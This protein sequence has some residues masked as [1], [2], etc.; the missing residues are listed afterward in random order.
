MLGKYLNS[1]LMTLAGAAMLV[2]GGKGVNGPAGATPTP[3]PSPT[4]PPAPP[5][6]SLAAPTAT[7]SS[8]APYPAFGHAPDYS[9]IAGQVMVTRIQGGC[10]YVRYGAGAGDE[11]VA[12]GG[13]GWAGADPAL[14]Q[15][16]ALVVIFGHIAGEG[17]P[18][19]MCPGRAFIV[20]RM[21]DNT[22][23]PGRAAL[24]TPT[25]VPA[26]TGV[27]VGTSIPGGPVEG[28]PLRD[29]PTITPAPTGALTP[30]ANGL[31]TVTEADNGRTAEMHLGDT[32]QL[33][34]K[35]DSGY[36]W[37][38]TLSDPSILN[39]DANTLN[40]N[41]QGRYVALARGQT[42]LSAVGLLPCHK[43]NPPCEAPTRGLTL[44]VIVR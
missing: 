5:T 33:A 22:G 32:L 3:E 19:E 41:G 43:V 25:V 34:L 44:Q 29:L 20:D 12:P 7:A 23:A 4:I 2:A 35:D 8:N 37:T 18:H 17:E 13:A 9:W 16:G 21:Q 31:I 30:D 24:P 1:L 27:I 39:Q 40:L 6:P 36:T 28:P 42:T 10:T 15:D 38:V 11:Q 14:T 26:S